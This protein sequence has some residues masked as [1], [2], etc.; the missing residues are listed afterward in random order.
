VLKS[1]RDR[2]HNKF[3]V[4]VARSIARI[5]GSGP[6]WRRSRFS[7]KCRPRKVLQAVEHETASLLGPVLAGRDG[8]VDL[9]RAR[10]GRMYGRSRQ[11][12]VRKRPRRTGGDHQL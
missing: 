10:G 4:S 11:S 5:C 7:E 9:R 1:L 6:C 2:L 8:G 12:R 3:N